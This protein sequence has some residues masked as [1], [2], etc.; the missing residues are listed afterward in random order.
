MRTIP[1]KWSRSAPRGDYSTTCDICGVRWRRSQLVRKADGLLYCPDDQPGRDAFTLSM[2]NAEAGTSRSY[3]AAPKDNGGFDN[4]APYT[5]VDP[6][7]SGAIL[8]EDGT[9]LSMEDGSVLILES[10]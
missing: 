1:N 4:D 8:L 3:D 2:L 7:V 10:A 6:G 9:Y 5:T